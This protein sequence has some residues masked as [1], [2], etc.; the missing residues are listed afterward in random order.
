MPQ[1]VSVK[2]AKSTDRCPV[3]SLLGHTVCGR[4][5]RVRTLR[6]W[7]DANAR[8]IAPALRIQSLFRGWSVRRYL[9][10]CGPGVLRRE[11]CVNDEDLCTTVEK[12]RQCPNDYFGLEEAGKVWWF[13][14]C[15]IWEWVSRS[16]EPLNP[17]T[18]VPI[19]P[20]DLQRLKKVW[21]LRRRHRYNVPSETG[22]LTADRIAR[23]WTL[24]CQVFRFYGFEDVHPR[25]FADMTKANLAIMFKILAR[26][27]AEMPQPS[28]RAL[29][30][31]MRGTTNAHTLSAG[32]YMMTSLNALMFM[33]MESS[34]YDFVFLTLS[35]LY[36]C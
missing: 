25:M 31:C 36:R 18:N 22:V 12:T 29:A 14:F 21:I 19:T 24:L 34:A 6:L 33:L 3:P 10:L 4:H 16:I 15:T 20:T 9:A 27:I 7:V 32:S 35:A 23:R 8:C 1:C 28:Q 13:D 30:L 17:Y 2:N 11:T 5:R 26:D